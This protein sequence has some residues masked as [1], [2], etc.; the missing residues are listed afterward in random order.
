MDAVITESTTAFWDRFLLDDPSAADRITA[1]ADVDG[2]S[3]LARNACAI[4]FI[5]DGGYVD[6][7]LDLS[8]CS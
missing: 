5:G 2:L 8:D 4:G 6:A 7:M 1:S 3:E